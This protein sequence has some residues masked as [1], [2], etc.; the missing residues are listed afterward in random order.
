VD[1]WDSLL[2]IKTNT[3]GAKAPRVSK[4][5][6]KSITKQV[7]CAVPFH[8]RHYTFRKGVAYYYN[9]RVRLVHW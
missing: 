8:P 1:A 3:A 4:R 2:G 5:F 7:H 6:G 9:I